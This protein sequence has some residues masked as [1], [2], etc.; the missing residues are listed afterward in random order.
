MNPAT[1]PRI[2][3]GTM[4]LLHVDPHQR[5]YADRPIREL[6]VLLGSDD[7]LVVND[8]ATLPASFRLPTVDA[9]LRLVAHGQGSSFTAVL[10]GAGDYRTRTED[11]PEPPRLERGQ[12]VL[13]APDLAFEVV[14]VDAASPRWIELC[15][16][17]RG[18]ELWSALYRHGRPIQYAHVRAPLEVW[19]V[20]NRFAARPW[21]FE[22][23]SAGQPL[24][25]ELLLA[26]ARRGVRV[27]SLTHAASIS[28]TGSAT[29]DARLPVPERYD[30]PEATVRAIESTRRRRGRVVA[31]GTT[32]VR[33]LE[34]CVADRGALAHG[35]GVARLLLSARFRPRVVSGVLS[36][37]HEPDT[38]HFALLQAFADSPLLRRAIAAAEHAGY[39]Q[40]EFGDALLI[41]PP[42]HLPERFRLELR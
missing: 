38:S 5:A 37:M 19:D 40:H 14:H 42:P 24:D 20:Q 16:D 10:F 25:G 21:A 28:S 26:L 9:E 39:L 34:A 12:R 31:V 15:F 11:R 3:R 33:A 27:A 32:V 22:L 8:A 23:P 29:L 17:V 13:V 30:I 6:A 36:G 41:L 4:R 2:D 18:A 7:L 1:S 35:E